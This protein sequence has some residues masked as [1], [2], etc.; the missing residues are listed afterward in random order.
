MKIKGI[1]ILSVTLTILLGSCAKNAIQST[2]MKT[3]MDSISYAIGVMEY[4]NLNTAL[5]SIDLNLILMAKGMLDSKD[6]KTEMTEDEARVI[7]NTYFGKLQSDQAAKEAEANKSLYKDYIE[8]NEKFLAQ[9]KEREGITVTPSGLQYE[10]IKMGTGDKPT[11]ESTVRVHYTGS[12]I[13]GNEFDSSR[14]GEPAEFPLA[15]VIPG[16]TEALQ[17]MPV[18][19]RFMVW[20]PSELAYGPNGAGDAIKPFSTLV[21]DVELIG[22]VK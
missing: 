5:D 22:I 4:M 21:F 18:G 16:W 20:L 14:K 2:K 13:D 6:E 19:S 8:E 10:V 9:N 1:M 7:L 15:N 11:A 3:E 12:T 17:L